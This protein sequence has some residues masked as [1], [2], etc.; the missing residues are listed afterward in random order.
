LPGAAPLRPIRRWRTGRNVQ[1]NI[2]VTQD[3]FDGFYRLA[4]NARFK[5]L[6]RS[7]P[8]VGVNSMDLMTK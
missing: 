4:D 5:A 7:Q 3:V 1:M 8:G 6:P 2:K